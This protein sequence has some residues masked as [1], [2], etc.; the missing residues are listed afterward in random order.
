M[1]HRGR[2]QPVMPSLRT[3]STSDLDLIQRIHDL[4]RELALKE[5]RIA[6]LEKERDK[7]RSE[8]TQYKF[9]LA[10]IL[11][12]FFVQWFFDNGGIVP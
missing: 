9:I 6:A 8:R 12:T 11:G 2:S 4:E 10:T 7:D 3:A 1:D 5:Q